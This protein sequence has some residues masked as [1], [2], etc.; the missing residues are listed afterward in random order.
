M[1]KAKLFIKGKKESI[2]LSEIEGRS[3]EQLIIDVN[4][5]KDTP[6]SIPGIWTG[7]KGDLRYV[8]FFETSGPVTF[9]FIHRDDFPDKVFQ[10]PKDYQ[11]KEGEHES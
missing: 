3:I 8:E 7:T 5:T 4:R 1:K 2:E 9:K 11:L 6:F 10:V